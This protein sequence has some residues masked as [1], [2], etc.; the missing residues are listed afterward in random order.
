MT[1]K[2]KL[3]KLRTDFKLTQEDLA[4][5]LGIS[6]SSIKN[7]ENKKKDRTPEI[8]VLKK[9]SKY[10]K[11]SMD[12][13]IH[14]NIE[15]ETPENIKINEITKLSDKAIYNLKKYNHKSIDLLIESEQLSTFNNLLDLYFKFSSL[16]NKI[17][18]LNIDGSTIDELAHNTNEIM[19]SYNL[20]C[21]DNNLITLYS[22]AIA[23]LENTYL[24]VLENTED[25]GDILLTELK[26]EY[27]DIYTTF[28]K[29]I[30]IVKLE[31]I[32]EF[33]KFLNTTSIS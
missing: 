22:N 10:F 29:A 18:Q 31:L 12:Y 14:D 30:K 8:S 7:Y 20:Y 21:D 26:E 19:K 33:S 25:R 23:N 6:T 9:Y 3:I 17:E 1:L 11:V 28:A 16:V 2:E 27:T 4:E 5:E 32:E 13:L 24:Y 15:N